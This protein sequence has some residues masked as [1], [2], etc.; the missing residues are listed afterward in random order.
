MYHAVLLEPRAG[1]PDTACF[2]HA[3]PQQG[4]AY[5]KDLSERVDEVLME[6]RAALVQNNEA[7]R[8]LEGSGEGMEWEQE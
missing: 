4:G 6:M 2:L 5:S 8:S 3:A 1:E 7:A